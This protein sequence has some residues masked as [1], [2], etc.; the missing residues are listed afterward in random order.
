MKF[1]LAIVEKNPE[2][3][4]KAVA[5]YAGL[6]PLDFTNLFPYWDVDES[7]KTLNLRVSIFCST[8]FNSFIES[9]IFMKF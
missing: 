2:L 9:W 7:A 4:P 3:P 6:E 1:V 5:V 8:W